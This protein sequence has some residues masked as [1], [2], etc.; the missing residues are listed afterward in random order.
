MQNRTG[1]ANHF[2]HLQLIDR[3]RAY[4]NLESPRQQALTRLDLT[5]TVRF[6][7]GLNFN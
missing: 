7:Y 6:L 3:I 1:V 4:Y 5:K 2:R